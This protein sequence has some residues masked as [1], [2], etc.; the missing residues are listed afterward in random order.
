MLLFFSEAKI[1]YT[2]RVKTGITGEQLWLQ[3]N[4]PTPSDKGK[5]VMELFDGKTGHTKVVDLSG[6]GKSSSISTIL[7]QM[8]IWLQLP[9]I[10]DKRSEAP[11]FVVQDRLGPLLVMW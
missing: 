9:A 6:Q 7:Q 3:I 10:W 8:K 5:Y 11:Y 1:K 2:E 4:E